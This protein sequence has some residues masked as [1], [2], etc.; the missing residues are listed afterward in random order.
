VASHFIVSS[1]RSVY[2]LKRVSFLICICRLSSVCYVMLMSYVYPWSSYVMY[3]LVVWFEGCMGLYL[4]LPM[5]SH[6]N[7]GFVNIVNMNG[8][9][10]SPCSMPLWMGIVGVLPCGVM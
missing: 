4:L 3:V 10:V 5:D 7:S 2:S 9:S 8:D 1:S 6:L